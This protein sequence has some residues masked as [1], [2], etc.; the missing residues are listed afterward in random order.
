MQKH[1]VFFFPT[2]LAGNQNP[3]TSTALP[4]PTG[5]QTLALKPRYVSVIPSL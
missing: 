1:P 5:G 2:I 3:G 4:G